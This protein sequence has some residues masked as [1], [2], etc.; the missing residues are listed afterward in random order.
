M[1]K[2]LVIKRTQRGDSN[3]KGFSGGEVQVGISK[4]FSLRPGKAGRAEKE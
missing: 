3:L 2:T 4:R 1:E